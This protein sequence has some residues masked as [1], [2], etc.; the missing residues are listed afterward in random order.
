MLF[1]THNQM[2]DSLYL[3]CLTL[4]IIYL[5]SDFDGI[6]TAYSV[7]RG[8]IILSPITFL[9]TSHI[10]FLQFNWNGFN[11]Q[12]GVSSDFTLEKTVCRPTVIIT[13]S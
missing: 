12:V 1:P 8:S 10:L 3:S 5:D 2:I 13:D 4:K 9:Y 6:Y 11:L 7:V